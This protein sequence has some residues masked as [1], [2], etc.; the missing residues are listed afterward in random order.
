MLNV[1]MMSGAIYMLLVYD[2]VLPSG[3]FPT[4]FG[5]FVILILLFALQALLEFVRS[6]ALLSIANS[7]H[8]SYFERVSQATVRKKLLG[9][10]KA[11]DGMQLVRDL[12]QVHSYLA[13]PGPAALVDLPWVILFLLVLTFLHWSLGL[14]A[15]GGVVVL[16]AIAAVTNRR[17]ARGNRAFV[18]VAGRR[19][20][21]ADAELRFAESAIAMGMAGRL[22]ER[23]AQLKDEFLASQS[24]LSRTI[25]RLGG[26]GRVFRLFLQS[27]ILTVGAVLVINGM[28]TGGIIIASSVLAGRALA[29][30]D[31]AIANWRGLVSAR[32]GWARI[33]D[34][35]AKYPP[36]QVRGIDLPPPSRTLD[37]LRLGVAPPGRAEMILN[38]V[39]F[40]L[41]SGDALAI[42]GPSAAGK[43]S[44][45][46]TIVGIWAPAAGEVRLDGATLDQWSEE[47]IGAKMGYLPQAAELL[48]GTIGQNIARFDPAASSDAVI[49]A[50]S[51]AGMHETILGFDNGYDTRVTSGG[52]ELSAG[53]RQR[54]GLARALF[55]DPFLV[56]LDEPSSN[57]DAAGDAALERAV[58]GIQARGGIVIMIT[59]RP[60]ALSAVSHIALLGAGRLV[61]FGKRDDVLQRMAAH[62][63]GDQAAPSAAGQKVTAR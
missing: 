23:S 58:N 50:A 52:F 36:P 34:A 43:T 44:L 40:S 62:T 25:S 47:V 27:L 18:S 10:D 16:A 30:V 59:H 32:T 17:T 45:A 22:R 42:I 35:L 38:G 8:R 2:S 12:D 41:K 4:L 60:A 19:A 63:A 20:A 3:S 5:L 1:L 24:F 29:P 6:E 56:V 7:L 31:Q 48:E 21:A 13:S 53:Q 37:V 26:A 33:V 39:N 14:A 61:D 15:L 11:G 46:K 55:N 49:A 54:L 28:A 9:S 51:A 57:L